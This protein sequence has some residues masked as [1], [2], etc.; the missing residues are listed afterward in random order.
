MTSS[1]PEQALPTP[2]TQEEGAREAS[3]DVQPQS[4]FEA[5]GLPPWLAST[6]RG[7]GYEKPTPIQSACIP[8]LIAGEDLI[9]QAQTGTGKT[10]AF[11][12][13][14]IVRLP[15]KKKSPPTPSALVLAPTRELAIQVASAIEGYGGAPFKSRVCLLYGGQPIGPQIGALRAQPPIVIGTPGRVLDHLSRGTL[16]LSE[17]RFA[18]LDEADEMLKMGFIEDV[19]E[20]LS[21]THPERQCALFSATMPPEVQRIAD[22]YLSAER[23]Q[24][25]IEGGRRTSDDV[26][27][28]T[29]EVP[30]E[31]KVA[32]LAA[33]LELT[34][35]GVKIV[36][37]RTRQDT[38]DL[39]DA[40]ARFGHQAEALNGEMGQQLREAVIN[41]L[42]EGT[43]DTLIATDVAARGLDI[44][45]VSLVVN[46]DLPF[47]S[48]SYIHRIGRTGRAGQRGR[49]VSL[50]EPRSRRA[51]YHLEQKLSQ[52]LTPHPP[53]HPVA[54][55]TARKERL[56][57]ELLERV[58]F[59]QP[60]PAEAPA[61]EAQ[62]A[63][64]QGAP[65][66]SS[67]KTNQEVSPYH[68]VIYELLEQGHGL[69]DL[70]AA[71][72]SLAAQGRPLNPK[73]LPLRFAPEELDPRKAK[74][75]RR[76]EERAMSKGA[77]RERPGGGRRAPRELTGSGGRVAVQLNVGRVNRVRP[78]D[79]VGAIANEGRI[80]GRQIGAIRIEE[81]SSYVELPPEV[82]DRVIDRLTGRKI[83][84]VRVKLRLAK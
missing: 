63:K 4:P 18:V 6:V 76:K 10:A 11:A 44:D 72:L 65:Q 35:E 48:E 56:K 75:L 5:L 79:L 68:E 30:R 15:K 1:S 50:I 26:E 71:A 41:R 53:I 24:V 81:R 23:A 52:R 43:L 73:R 25:K 45:N 57:L 80:E 36:F 17:V 42:R 49:A 3:A 14:L 40:L 8:R 7:L 37:A 31:G 12:L 20:I 21:H 54:L 70:A 69:H 67:T 62:E 66:D 64:A 34:T 46:Y 19:S 39:V 47:D 55:L 82:V 51:L 9:G 29:L 38:T 61:D 27:Q 60:Q 77:R 22:T 78:Q 13:P 74:K 84:G 59:V 33:L 32:G 83:C 16:D 2:Q 28:L 58:S